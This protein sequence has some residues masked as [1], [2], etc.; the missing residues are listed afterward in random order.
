[1]AFVVPRRARCE[2]RR[3]DKGGSAPGA[4]GDHDR[5]CNSNVTS[6]GE[7]TERR[8]A[9]PRSNVRV[10][11]T[12]RVLAGR[13]RLVKVIGQGGMAVVHL[14]HDELLDRDVAVKV[15]RPGFDEDPEFVARF[16]REARHAASLHHPNIVTIFDTGIDQETGSDYIVMELVDGLDLQEILKRSGQLEI[17]FAVRI[18]AGLY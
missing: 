9:A 10:V 7:A 13:Y 5:D 6:R 17:G 18:R 3:W 8:N 2:G 14:A 11:L 12:E 4:R 1:M 15:L 16:R